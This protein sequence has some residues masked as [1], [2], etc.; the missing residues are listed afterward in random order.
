MLHE[1]REGWHDFWSRPWLWAIVL[2]FGVV[3]AV[4]NGVVNVLGPEVAQK[5]LGGAAGWARRA[6]GDDRRA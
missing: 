1:L 3:N 2:Q 5:H 4:E 6:D